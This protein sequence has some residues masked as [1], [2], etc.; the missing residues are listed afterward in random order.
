MQMRGS[1]GKNCANET[2]LRMARG[3]TKKIFFGAGQ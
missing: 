3:D 1:K 2:Q